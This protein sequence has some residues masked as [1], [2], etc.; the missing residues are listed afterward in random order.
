MAASKYKL[1]YFDWTGLAEI[2]RLMF[3]YADVPYEDNRIPIDDSF[4]M[5]S[6]DWKAKLPWGQVPVLDV[7]GKQLAQARAINRFLARRFKLVSTNDFE[8][9]KCDEVVDAFLDYV[10]EFQGYFREMDATK[11]KEIMKT[12]LE[13]HTPKFLSKFDKLV[14]TN[15]K[16][17]V[18]NGWT[19]ADFT[20]HHLL[21]YFE[22]FCKLDLYGKYPALKTGKDA[23][24]NEP[25]IKKWVAT[26]PPPPIEFNDQVMMEMVGKRMEKMNK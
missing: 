13:V 10:T 25:K 11:K 7:D 1:T 24:F 19:W 17:L 6:E 22:Q 23:F 8:S 18:G 12:L 26:R 3:A 15:G 4:P 20:V 5:L 16:Y 14:E 21:T 9:A 2:T